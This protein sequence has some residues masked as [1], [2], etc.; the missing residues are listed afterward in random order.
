MKALRVNVCCIF[1]ISETGKG[2]LQ[3]GV[4]TSLEIGAFFVQ[5]LQAWHNDLSSYNVLSL[6]T[7]PPPPVSDD[8]IY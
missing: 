6:P 4:R 7:V 2:L 3:N 8:T 5:F 1:S